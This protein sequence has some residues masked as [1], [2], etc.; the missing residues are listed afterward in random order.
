MTLALLG[1]GPTDLGEYS[2]FDDPPFRKGAMTCVLDSLA[3]YKG[4]EE[5]AYTLFSRGDASKWIK[6]SKRAI[7]ARPKEVDAEKR[8]FYQAA[9]FLG[10][11]A[12]ENEKTGA[13]F[14]H[15]PDHSNSGSKKTDLELESAML[16]GFAKVGFEAGVPMVP[17]PRS[18]A[19]LMAY[20]QKYLDKQKEY[21][22]SE[23]FEQYPANDGSPND[24]KTLL[25]GALKCKKSEEVYA[26]V[27][28]EI[29]DIDWRRVSTPSY[30][31]F[32]KRFEA[33]VES[34]LKSIESAETQ[35]AE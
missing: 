27:M 13:V 8:W 20:F 28:E 10:A 34:Y 22:K 6:E 33:V 26:K 31:R 19:W 9:C 30:D 5:I 2:A 25:Q 32:R 14:F 18:E 7:G 21:N 24:L 1:E 12:K 15:D 35:S 11:Q 17:N 4:V 16:C 23:R 29:H 3:G